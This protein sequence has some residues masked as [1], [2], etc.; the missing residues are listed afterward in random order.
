MDFTDQMNQPVKAVHQV[1]E[2]DGKVPQKA[3]VKGMFLQANIREMEECA[4]AA[5]NV[6]EEDINQ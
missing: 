3:R 5:H 6:L 2:P 1:W 4:K